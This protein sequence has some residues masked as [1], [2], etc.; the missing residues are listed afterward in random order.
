[1]IMAS[2]RLIR[3]SLAKMPKCGGLRSTIP[4]RS[5]A[6]GPFR[7]VRRA[8]LEQHAGGINF[9]LEFISKSFDV[10]I[11]GANAN[12]RYPSVCQSRLPSGVTFE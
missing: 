5:S 2:L 11:T 6:T 3:A 9:R 12:Q 8:G 1:M 10:E 7:E 4:T